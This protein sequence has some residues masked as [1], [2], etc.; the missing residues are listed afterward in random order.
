[1]DARTTAISNQLSRSIVVR[2]CVDAPPAKTRSVIVAP[3]ISSRIDFGAHNNDLPNLLRALNERVF[4]VEG[5]DGLV[6]PP[7]PRRGWWRSLDHVSHRLSRRVGIG[8]ER[9][10]GQEFI[11]K[12]PANKRALYARAEHEYVSRG[13]SPRDAKIK[14]FVKFEKLN[15]T[16]KLDPAPR[17]IQPRTPVYN[18]AL[19]RFTRKIEEDVYRALADEW[20]EGGL[21]VV[22]KGLTVTG[23]ADVLWAKWNRLKQPY[24]VSLDAKRFDQHVSY[25]ALKWE[26]SVY[27]RI[28]RDPELKALLRL[29]LRNKGYAC[30]DGHKVTYE[31]IGSRAS[32]DMNTSLGNCLIMCTLMREYVREKGI[33]A[34]F[35]NNGDDCVF[36]IEKTQYHLLD[37]LKEWFLEAGFSMTVDA[38]TEVFE[39]IEFCQT[40][41]VKTPSGWVMVRQPETALAKDALCLGASTELAFRQ[42]CYQVGVGGYA[43]YGDMPI[44]SA[45]YKFYQRVGVKSH[46]GSSFL[47]SDSWFMRLTKTPRIRDG[48]SVSVSDCTR[49]SFYKAFG[50]PPS[51]QVRIEQ[52]LEAGTLDGI[53]NMNCNVSPAVGVALA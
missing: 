44:F 25:D 26:H 47:L 11:A 33:T 22:M 10:T 9:L 46:V 28:F 7:K 40:Q 20:E 21:P 51:S 49:L 41:P 32:G 29:Q 27:N 15:F 45:L 6:P 23:V 42:W 17:V 4:N 36:M 19:G 30:L 16:K 24:A 3:H 12:C 1:M 39:E 43:L 31:T 5:K 18:Y 38:E 50:V 53:R 35:V 13:W 48:D 34:Q 37:D 8:T 14:A 2:P 52:Y